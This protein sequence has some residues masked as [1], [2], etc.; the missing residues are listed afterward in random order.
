MLQLCIQLNKQLYILRGKQKQRQTEAERDT[1]AQRD[2]R[3]HTERQAEAERETQTH[4]ETTRTQRQPERSALQSSFNHKSVITVRNDKKKRSRK[5]TNNT[6]W[7]K[8]EPDGKHRTERSQTIPL[9]RSWCRMKH[10]VQKG[11]KQY[12][13]V[14]GGV[15]GNTVQKGHKQYLLVAGGVGGNTVQKG[16]K[17]YLLVGGGV[18]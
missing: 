18:G 10:T 16:H 11:H 13:L 6:S 5:E 9:G 7:Q 8:M 4:T 12:L 3:L 1:D 17:Q 14:G 15:G 2:K